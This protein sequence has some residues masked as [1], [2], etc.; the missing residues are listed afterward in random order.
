MSDAYAYYIY[1]EELPELFGAVSREAL[2][3]RREGHAALADRLLKGY[4]VLL[5][6]LE[7]VA[8]T[9][10]GGGTVTLIESER[11]TQ[12]RPPTLG[13]GGPQLEDFLQCDPLEALPGSVGVANE[14][15]LDAG[16]PWWPTNEE[17]SSARVGGTVFGS[18]FG[19]GGGSGAAPDPGQF[20]E[21]PIFKAGEGFSPG[22]MTIENPIPARRFIRDAIP[23]IDA[24]WFRGFEAAKGKLEDVITSVF[25]DLAAERAADKVDRDLERDIRDLL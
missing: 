24:Q 6:D 1:A 7:Y 2:I 4:A 22:L 14:D 17:G 20:R 10:A 21:H 23:D 19:A 12:V 16:V 25:V 8:A 5:E 13:A 18:F 15:V 9:V 3:L 11:K